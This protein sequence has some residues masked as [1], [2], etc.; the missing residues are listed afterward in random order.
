LNDDEYNVAKYIRE[1]TTPQ[2][3]IFVISSNT[4]IYFLSERKPSTRVFFWWFHVGFRKEI[5]GRLQIINSPTDVFKNRPKYIVHSEDQRLPEDWKTLLQQNYFEEKK[6]GK[7]I[8]LKNIL[9]D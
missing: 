3:T 7:Y 1:H 9:I 4:A 2:D 5:L 8:I 6:I